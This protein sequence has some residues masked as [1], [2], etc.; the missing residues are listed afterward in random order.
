MRGARVGQPGSPNPLPPVPTSL[1][2]GQE[3]G[4]GVESIFP[5]RRGCQSSSAPLVGLSLAREDGRAVDPHFHPL[6]WT[7]DLGAYTRQQLRSLAEAQATFVHEY[8]HYV[9]SLTGT[10]GRI[11][12]VELVRMCGLAAI[13]AR[14]GAT[15]PKL[16]EQLD[17]L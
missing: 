6:K 5:H 2:A 1:Q 4:Q 11:Y 8:I 10:L 15:P 9:Q 16:E 3:S 17:I 7:I 14:Y 13:T 12:L